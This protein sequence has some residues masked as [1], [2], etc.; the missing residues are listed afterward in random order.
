MLR[1]ALGHYRRMA[2]LLAGPGKAKLEEPLL[3]RDVY[4]ERPL[5]LQQR[6]RSG[7]LPVLERGPSVTVDADKGEEGFCCE[8][9]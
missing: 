8:C 3:Q 2:A 5:S 9:A 1:G 6:L 7:A 4:A